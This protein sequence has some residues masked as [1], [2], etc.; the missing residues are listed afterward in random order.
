MEQH[1][2]WRQLD[3]LVLATKASDDASY[4]TGGEIAVDG[5]RTTA[6]ITRSR[7]SPE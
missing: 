2:R 7:K 1:A 4:I 6:S 3:L 5:G